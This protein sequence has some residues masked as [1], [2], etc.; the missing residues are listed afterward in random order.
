MQHNLSD[1]LYC[2]NNIIQYILNWRL[3]IIQLR[4]CPPSNG[5]S[6]ILFWETRSTSSK[7]RGTPPHSWEVGDRTLQ[8]LNIRQCCTTINLGIYHKSLKQQTIW[9]ILCTL[10]V[11]LAICPPFSGGQINILKSGGGRP[12]PLMGSMGGRTP[13]IW[14]TLRLCSCRP[15]TYAWMKLCYRQ[16]YAGPLREIRGARGRRKYGALILFLFNQNRTT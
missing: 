10:L 15:A 2:F 6:S 3:I 16:S 11:N 9:L 4:L 5:R 1:T 8:W 12:P 14:L 13:L 7:W